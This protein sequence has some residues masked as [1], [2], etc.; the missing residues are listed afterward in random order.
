MSRFFNDLEEEKKEI[1]KKFTTPQ[2][3]VEKLSKKDKLQMEFETRVNELIK[4]PKNIKKFISDLK[5]YEKLDIPQYIE[6]FLLSSKVYQKN[7]KNLIDNFLKKNIETNDQEEEI[8]IIN[9]VINEIDEDTIY[10]NMLKIKDK[11]ERI[12]KMTESL[13]EIKSKEIKINLLIHILS[14]YTKDKDT[15]KIYD[16]FIKILD[17]HKNQKV[18]NLLDNNLNFY[19]DLFRGEDYKN[20]LEKIKIINPDIYK[21]RCLE[22]DFINN[23]FIE[24]DQPDF[25]I[26]FL[27][28]N[29]RLE[30]SLEI[31]KSLNLS[32]SHDEIFRNNI[33]KYADYL[34][35]NKK[36]YES[37]QCYIFLYKQEESH[38]IKI[39]LYTLCVILNKEI[40]EDD[41]FKK[42]LVDFKRFGLNTFVL[43]SQDKIFEIFRSFY[44]LHCY[45]S[46][47][48][49]NILHNINKDFKDKECLEEF[50]MNL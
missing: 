12:K 27:I 20:I 35:N 15:E 26:I 8:Q 32:G 2:K 30:D 13:E 24:T 40:Q 48:A 45:D 33:N 46:E 9:T 4:N 14:V 37:Y 3:Q 17:F 1:K 25:N 10:E 23:K 28:K 29:N 47:E 16:I 22:I 34:F 11:Q 6:E 43:K 18:K 31:F 19:L 7:N 38:N 39:I 21:R 41:F 44:L 36:Y 5:K 42:F 49:Y 50:V